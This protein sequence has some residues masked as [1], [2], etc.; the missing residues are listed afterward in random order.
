MEEPKGA[1]KTPRVFL[2]RSETPIL[3][4]QIIRSQIAEDPKI[5]KANFTLNGPQKH[6]GG[7]EVSLYSFLNFGP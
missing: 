6:R 1:R 4:Y 5:S 2:S 3:R 7:V